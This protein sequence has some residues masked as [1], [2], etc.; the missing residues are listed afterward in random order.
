MKLGVS[1]VGISHL[2]HN[3]R[4]PISR[5]YLDCKDNFTEEILKP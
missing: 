3:N 5:S 1:L 4:W 2:I